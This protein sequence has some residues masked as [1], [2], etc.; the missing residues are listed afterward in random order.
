MKSSWSATIRFAS[1]PTAALLTGVSKPIATFSST[2]TAAVSAL[3][4]QLAR[5][6]TAAAAHDVSDDDEDDDDAIADDGAEDIG[7]AYDVIVS[8]VAMPR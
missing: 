5:P 3:F 1:D 8:D 6:A 7:V 4:A 2:A